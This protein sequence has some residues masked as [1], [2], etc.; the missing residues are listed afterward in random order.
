MQQVWA[1]VAAA[2]LSDGPSARFSDDGTARLMHPLGEGDVV[3]G[4]VQVVRLGG[5]CQWRTSLASSVL[6]STSYRM[7]YAALILGAVCDGDF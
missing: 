3:E 2:A 5:V 7:L 1:A 6:T 4:V